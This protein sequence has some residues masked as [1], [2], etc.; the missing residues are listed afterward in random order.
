MMCWWFL[1]VVER[2]VFYV[3]PVYDITLKSSQFLRIDHHQ[4]V[5]SCSFDVTKVADFWGSQA[6]CQRNHMQCCEMPFQ[7]FLSSL[8]NH[9]VSTFVCEMLIEC[10]RFSW[11]LN[12]IW[13]LPW[14][15]GHLWAETNCLYPGTSQRFDG[16]VWVL[17]LPVPWSTTAENTS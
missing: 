4:K 12:F 8:R 16:R 2:S 11:I 6:A 10:D 1:Q 9:V 5:I 17:K 14:F 13:V 7:R 3:W 15:S